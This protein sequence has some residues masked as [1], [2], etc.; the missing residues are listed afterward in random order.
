M[1]ERQTFF[2][3][4]RGIAVRTAPRCILAIFALGWMMLLGACSGDS[5]SGPVE[6]K[7]DR[8]A[9]ERCRMVLSDRRHSAQVRVSKPN[10]RSEVF[11]FDDIG[12][13]LIW[14]E[15]QPPEARKSP[16]TEIWVN[17]WR[18][19]HWI[20]ARTASY[21][22][23]QVT[24]MGYGLGAQAEPTKGGTGFARAKEH[25]FEVE[26]RFNLHGAHPDVPSLGGSAQQGQ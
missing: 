9:C 5:G 2:V 7:W 17:D 26:R 8:V 10:G 20:D 1:P 24:P 19:G 15:G 18:D 12:C 4:A 13:A 23:G 11:F 3:L 6:V 14:L 25:V 16:P 22:P 21:V